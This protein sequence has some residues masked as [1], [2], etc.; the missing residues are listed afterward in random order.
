M[1]EWANTMSR[2]S[3][4]PLIFDANLFNLHCAHCGYSL[5]GLSQPRCPECGGAIDLSSHFRRFGKDV[6]VY[7]LSTYTLLFL[8]GFLS[9]IV[10]RLGVIALIPSFRWAVAWSCFVGTGSLVGGIW[11]I[12]RRLKERAIVL[13]IQGTRTSRGAAIMLAISLCAVF[14]ASFFLI[15]IVVLLAAF[16][17]SYIVQ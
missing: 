6:G 14:L 7:L 10:W 12:R 1:R 2:E 16:V 4:P 11:F 3:D 15:E 5:R 17:V 13:R 8:C 9:G